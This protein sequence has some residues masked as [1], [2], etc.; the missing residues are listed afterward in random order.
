[1]LATD[2]DILSENA[3]AQQKGSGLR[4]PPVI[5][6]DPG[7]SPKVLLWDEMRIAPLLNP[8]NDGVVTSGA[9][10]R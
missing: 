5:S 9:G 4:P 3:M 8:A 2:T 1:V 7:A 10:S 6:S